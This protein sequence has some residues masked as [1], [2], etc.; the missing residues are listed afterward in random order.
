MALLGLPRD[1]KSPQTTVA[2]HAQKSSRTALGR[3]SDRREGAAV[4]PGSGAWPRSLA[5]AGL[6]HTV[7][8]PLLLLWPCRHPGHH[9]AGDSY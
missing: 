1:S 7:S 5:S 6:G 8:R 3:L 4:A 2:R 9:G